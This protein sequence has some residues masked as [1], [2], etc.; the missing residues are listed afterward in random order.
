MDIKEIRSDFLIYVVDDE[1]SICEILK[2]SLTG[3]GFQVETFPSAEDALSRVQEAPPH[4]ILSDI[5][6]PGMNGIQL[7]EK[8]RDLSE[9]IQFII[10]TSHASLDTAVNAMRLGAYDYLNKPFE[11]LEDVIKTVDRTIEKLYLKFQNE[12]LLDELELKNDALVQLN[13]RIAKEK[14]EVV[15]INNLMSQ[16]ALAK[17]INAVIESYLK[18]VNSL[19]GK[20]VVFMKHLPSYSSLVVSHASGI[21]HEN[22]R[23]I[24]ISFKEDDPKVY[25]ESLKNPQA[26][27]KLMHL[28]KEVF[29]VDSFLALPLETSDGMAGTIVVFD[30]IEDVSI[31]RL[32]ESFHQIFKVFYSSALLQQKIHDMAIKD[33]LTGLYNRR[34]FNERLEAEISRSR[35]TRHPVSLIYMDIDNFKNYN[36]LNGHPMGDVLLRMVSTVLMKT[37]R[38]ND[39][40]ARIGGEE[41]VVVLPHTDKEGAAIKAEKLRRTLWAT[42]FPH[43]E[44]Q[45]L[46]RI[47]MSM[48]VSSYPSL[49][50]DAETLVQAADAAL[51]QAKETTRNRVC[52]A[53]A[54]EGFEPDFEPIPVE[55][56]SRK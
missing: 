18:N 7:L 5:R 17:E 48:G 31:R 11:E 28:M 39:I 21:E 45:P 6:M 22:L 29:G 20:P 34:Y 23:R 24:G 19:I 26:M 43:G 9:D 16:L 4:V 8:V 49:A 50:N 52:L 27:S 25:M 44:K 37:S 30:K 42:D 41:F 38:K 12:Q 36:D 55:P 35:R 13:A 15:L 51:Y 40:V 46:G 47:S 10:M 1:Q 33:P 53:V 54:P 14:E 2:E 56:Y 3:A 32:Y